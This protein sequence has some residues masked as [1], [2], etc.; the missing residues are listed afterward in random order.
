MDERSRALRITSFVIKLPFTA[1][2]NNPL[3]P[4]PA[5]QPAAMLMGLAEQTP[6]DTL[7]CAGDEQ[8]EMKGTLR[9]PVL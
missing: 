3:N 8:A 9:L 7:W 6:T 4:V 5:S 1:F 2:N